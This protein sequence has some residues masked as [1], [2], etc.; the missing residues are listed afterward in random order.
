[1]MAGNC[2]LPM[3][4]RTRKRRMGECLGARR[5]AASTVTLL[6]FGGECSETNDARGVQCRDVEGTGSGGGACGVSWRKT[7]GERIMSRRLPR[8]VVISRSSSWPM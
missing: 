4:T 1:M 7:K 2:M 3:N 5:E 8:E 6:H